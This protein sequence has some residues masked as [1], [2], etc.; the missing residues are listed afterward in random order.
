MI[1]GYF[2]P[3]VAAVAIYTARFRIV[4]V[5]QDRL[6]NVFMT[7]VAGDSY[8]PEA[9]SVIFLMTTETG[10]CQVRTSQLKGALVMHFNGKSG[11]LKSLEGMAFRTIGG[12]VLCHELFFMIISVAINTPAVPDIFCIA[13]FMATGTCYRLMPALK[14]VTGK[15]MIKSIHT[16]Y[17]VKG[18]FR[19]TFRTGLS[20]S[21]FMNILVAICTFSE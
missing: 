4:F 19:M 7:I 17:L 3:F 20:E 21:I 12:T 14:G 5:L 1:K 18:Y 15:G 10:S 13:C 16:L 11:L 6:M 8:L 2:A 9:P